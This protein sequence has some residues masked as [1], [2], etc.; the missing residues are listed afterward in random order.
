MGVRR[1]LVVLVLGWALLYSRDGDWE[2]LHEFPSESSCS[3]VRTASVEGEIQEEMGSALAGQPADNPMR[4]EAYR[5]AQRR[6]TGR[7]RC[8]HDE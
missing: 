8:Q 3:R 6:V 7:Y 1:L 2:V 5:R 4:Q